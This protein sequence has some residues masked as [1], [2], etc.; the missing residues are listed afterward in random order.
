MT[1]VRFE[2]YKNDI[3]WKNLQMSRD[4][5]KV[6]YDWLDK[7]PIISTDADNIN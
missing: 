3:D 5:R 1:L 7:I 2:L 6:R 4:N